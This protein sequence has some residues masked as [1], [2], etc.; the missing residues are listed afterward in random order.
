[1]RTATK[2]TEVYSFDE[3][4]ESAKET[5][6]QWWRNC[7]NQDFHV[8]YEDFVNVAKILGIEFDPR[9]I[10][11]MDGS[12]RKEPSIYWSGFYHQGSGASFEGYYGYAKKAP[13]LIREYAPKDEDLHQIADSLQAIQR[14][15]FYRLNA[16]ISTRGNYCHEYSMTTA[17]DYDGDRWPTDDEEEALT[18]C[19]RSFARW[20]YRQIESEYEYVMSDENVDESIR[21]NEYEFTENGGIY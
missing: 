10:P 17:T 19:F 8:D 7:E 3:L 15:A 12:S 20:I 13:K 21:I 16:R 4:D 11:L 1:M 2:M 6:R 9:D 18:E 14:P 5:A